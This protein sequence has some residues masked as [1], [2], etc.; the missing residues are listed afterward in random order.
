MSYYGDDSALPRAI[1]AASRALKIDSLQASPHLALARIHGLLWDWPKAATELE[2]ALDEEPR[3][4]EAW[5]DQSLY[6]G[7]QGRTS[8][9][10]DAMKKAASLDPLST[11]YAN[12]LGLAYLNA[13]RVNDAAAQFRR[14]QQDGEPGEARK[15]RAY[16]ARCLVLQGKAVQGV[17]ALRSS[18][19]APATIYEEEELA[20]ALARADR[21]VEALQLVA[22][23][24]G[25]AEGG[26][27]SPLAIAAMQVAAG[28]QEAAFATL[29]RACEKHDPRLLWLGVDQRFDPIRNDG[30]FRSLMERMHLPPMT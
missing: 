14:A 7:V 5:Y 6:F 27:A 1:A 24:Q 19:S 9:E 18:G 29:F 26:F 20:Y 12:E 25:T 21:R 16:W 8:E 4:P 22:R 17:A 30:R 11:R 15:A 3:N 13:R 2:T 23:L 10:V 28:E